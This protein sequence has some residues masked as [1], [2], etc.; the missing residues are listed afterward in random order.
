MSSSN[1]SP[2]P[3]LEGIDVR[4]T[5]V[6]FALLIAFATAVAV[7]GYSIRSFALLFA[8][9]PVSAIFTAIGGEFVIAWPVDAAV[10]LAAASWPGR[11]LDLFDAG[12]KRAMIIIVGGA[13]IYGTLMS[14]LVEPTNA[15]S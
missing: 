5:A 13:L 15:F 7:V 3:D 9:L 8:G 10:W 12:W 11:Q 4:S 14:L 6:A 2:S 1:P